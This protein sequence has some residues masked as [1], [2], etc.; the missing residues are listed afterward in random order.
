M[1][2]FYI[3]FSVYPEAVAEVLFKEVQEHAFE[4]GYKWTGTGKTI[5]KYK[6]YYPV[7]IFENNELSYWIGTPR[8]CKKQMSVKEFLEMKK[9]P[10]YHVGMPMVQ[11][12][13]NNIILYT[14]CIPSVSIFKGIGLSHKYPSNNYNERGGY[15]HTAWKPLD[16]SRIKVTIY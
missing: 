14:K 6:K 8:I 3:D 9:E 13:N 4:L 11:R 16:P 2:P 5:E 12:W 15:S 1:T 10:E 7:T